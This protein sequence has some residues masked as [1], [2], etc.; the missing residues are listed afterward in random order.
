MQRL[1]DTG[2]RIYWIVPRI[3][4]GQDDDV[5]GISVAERVD[6][7]KQHFPKAGVLG[8]HGRMK[9]KDKQQVLDAFTQGTCCLLVSTTVVEVGVNVAEARLIVVDQ[10]DH[11]GLAQLHQLRGRVGRSHEQGYCILLPDRDISATGL[12]RL[13]MMVKSHDGLALAEKDLQLR[14][15]GDA[16]GTRQSG[17]AGFRL[18]DISR[19]ISWVQQWHEHLPDFEIT[20]AMVQ[21]WRPLADSVD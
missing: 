4:E 8:L 13:E 16:I 15:A 14:G 12:Q 19:D 3:D 17:D 7:L 11:Y 18:L 21:F 1:L 20:D 5:M 6:I 10:A 2:G 9:S